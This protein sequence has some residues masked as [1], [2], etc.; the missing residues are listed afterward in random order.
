MNSETNMIVQDG[1]TIM[2]G[3]ILFQE[4]SAIKRKLPLLGDIPLVGGLFQHNDIAEVNNELIIFITPYVIDEPGEMLPET[5]KE[6][7]GPRQKL[8]DVQE[9]LQIMMQQLKQE[10]P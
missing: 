9:E 5:L 2:L 8:E 6:I 10:H 1:Q 7:E 3:G 4:K